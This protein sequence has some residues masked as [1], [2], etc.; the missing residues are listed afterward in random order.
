MIKRDWL[1]ILFLALMAVFQAGFV[2]HFTVFGGWWFEW[3]NFVTAPVAIIAVFE[4]R[5]RNLGWFAAISGGLFLD[6]YSAR[7]FGFWVI[8]LLI[9][10]ALVKFGIKKYVRI[11]SYW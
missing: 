4:H 6:I 8:F 3:V 1:T 2:S 10:T 7:F 11:P 5:R 9:L